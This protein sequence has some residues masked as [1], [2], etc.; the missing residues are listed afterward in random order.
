MSS[1]DE[2]LEKAEIDASRTHYRDDH[3]GPVGRP[4]SVSSSDSTSSSFS[5][6]NVQVADIN[7]VPTT[8]ELERHPTA[9]SR[10]ATYRS[11]HSGTVGA[12]LKSRVSKK[13]LPPFGAG[14]PYPPPLPAQEEFV[15]EFSGVDDELHPQNWTLRKK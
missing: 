13:P 14:K 7:R 15:V 10:I 4:N 12:G 2:Q 3:G 8:Y 11:Q 9:L 5:S 1:V 6:E